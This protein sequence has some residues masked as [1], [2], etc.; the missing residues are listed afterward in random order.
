MKQELIIDAISLIDDELIESTDKIRRKFKRMNIAKNPVLK[1]AVAIVM[2]VCLI[3]GTMMSIPTVRAAVVDVIVQWFEQFT[4]FAANPETDNVSPVSTWVP[5]YLPEGYKNIETITQDGISQFIYSNADG[6]EI[7]F[8]YVTGIGSIS[9]NNEKVTYR[10]ET[11]GS[12]IYQIFESQEAGI[13]SSIVWDMNGYS[14]LISGECPI[15]E[16]MKIAVS[17]E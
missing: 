7:V 4:K 1:H 13:D 11:H 8:T 2:C 16:L 3:F 15:D 10:T 17:V 14:F 9:V 12:I 6:N 5:Q